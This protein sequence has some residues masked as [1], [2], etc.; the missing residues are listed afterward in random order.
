M[1]AWKLLIIDNGSTD[2]S[3]DIINSYRNLLPLELFT[4]PIAGKNRALNRAMAALEGDLIV[5]TDDDAVPQGAFLTA[6][7][8]FIT[9]KQEYDIFGGT[10]EPYFDAE[11]PLWLLR[12][13][14]Q[15]GALFAVRDL[16]EGP[17]EPTEIFGP[18]MAVRRW[19][20]D[21]GYRFNENIG[22]DGSDPNYPMG[23]ETEFCRRLG[24]Q[25]I[26]AWFA[27][28][29][30]VRHIIRPFQISNA[31]CARRAYRHGRGVARQL[32]D[33]GRIGKSHTR[34]FLKEGMWL[35]LKMLQMWSPLPSQ[36][37]RGVYDFNWARGF[38]EE[39]RKA[40]Q[41]RQRPGQK[42]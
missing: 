40:P 14:Y 22:P 26:S 34:P 25:G 38:K 24:R 6:W 29:P 27:R 41:W 9:S 32:G 4:E 23:S 31:Y 10:I 19:V 39:I 1:G 18:N 37:R 7:S 2:E 42:Q 8:R 33:S 13:Q 28:E 21:H 3:L 16:P 5:I 11:P 15:F 20:F 17:I 36:R 35:I 12:D 30:V